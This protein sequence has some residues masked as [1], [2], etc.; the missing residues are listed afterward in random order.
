MRASSPSQPVTL[1]D[2]ALPWYALYTRHQHE[3]AIATMLSS[4]GFEIFLPLHS[5]VHHWKDRR[6]AVLL[7]IFPCYVFLRLQGGGDRRF[8]VVSTPG[9]YS[10]VG[11]GG[12]PATIPQPEIDAIRRTVETRLGI[13]PHP[14]L[15]SGDWVRVTSGPLEG[16]EGML[17]RQKSLCR[18][19]LSVELL[20]KS[21]AVEVGA[22]TVERITVRRPAVDA[23]SS[24]GRFAAWA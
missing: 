24:H 17:V 19:V 7:P 20:Q 12:H 18:L 6:K 23:G 16:I 5:A 9:V 8:Q 10:F 15:K 11:A 14:F 21:V 4:K 22:E 2:R 13:E 1:S 3:R